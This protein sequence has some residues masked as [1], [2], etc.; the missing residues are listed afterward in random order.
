MKKQAVIFDID[1]TLADHTHRLDHIKRD[2]TT[3]WDD[4][5]EDCDKDEPIHPLINM[6]RILFNE[7]FEIMLC[8]G[9]AEKY[10]K[11]TI[12]WLRFYAVPYRKLM[13][14]PDGNFMSDFILKK[15]MLD[16]IL[17]DYEVFMVFEDRERVTE[18]YRENGIPCMQVRKSTY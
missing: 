2:G 14:R 6:S 3:N 7:G 5:T 17:E 11:K 15:E 18:M 4:F 1:G 9:R 16:I 8:T 13:M 10:S 12:H